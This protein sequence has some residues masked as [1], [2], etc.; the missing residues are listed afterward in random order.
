MRYNYHFHSKLMRANAQRHFMHRLISL[1]SILLLI[2]VFA[3]LSR[4][5]S[6]NYTRF[7]SGFAASF[8]RV[9]VSYLAA[10]TIAIFLAIIATR[11]RLF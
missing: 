9:V 1:S 4:L 11:N 5:H 8:G 2:A 3:S 7:Y 6:I 10:V